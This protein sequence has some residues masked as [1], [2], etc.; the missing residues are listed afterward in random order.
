MVG[1]GLEVSLDAY[2][3]KVAETAAKRPHERNA[4]GV[5]HAGDGAPLPGTWLCGLYP[6]ED[7]VHAGRIVLAVPGGGD[8]SA[9]AEAL[10]GHECVDDVS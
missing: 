9:L 3:R 5:Y 10:C 6:L 7:H 1:I 4:S 8:P 2:D